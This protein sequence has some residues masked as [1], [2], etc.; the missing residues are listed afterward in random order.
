[1]V[2]LESQVQCLMYHGSRT[3]R[4][5]E[6]F[7]CKWGAYFSSDREYAVGYAGVFGVGQLYDVV[8]DVQSPR[9]LDG[10]VPA[11]HDQFTQT[12]TLSAQLVAEG[13]DS[14]ILVFAD[15][16]IQVRVTRPC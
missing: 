16:E 1:M 7:A 8:L 12:R 15:G 11:V 5:L 4:P 13:F 9:Y 14:E 2:G 3:R 10:E 6:R